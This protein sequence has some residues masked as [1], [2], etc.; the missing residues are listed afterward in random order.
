M[1]TPIDIEPTSDRELVLARIIDAPPE[2]VFEAW[3]DPK[4]VCEWWAPRPWTTPSCEIEPRVGGVL[5]TVMRSPEGVDHPNA[6]VYL[7]IVPNQRIVWTDAFEKAWVP[8]AKPFM[9][10]V[11][12]FE[13]RGD[14]TLYTARALHWTVA[15]REEHERMGFHG[16]WGLCAEQLEELLAKR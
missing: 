2:R 7:E 16:G 4:L 5:Q 15:D 9:T 11:I 8:S 12:T 10:A 1:T 6:G 13:A 14:R 3:T